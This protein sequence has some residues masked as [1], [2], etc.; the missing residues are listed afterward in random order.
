MAAS[1][2]AIATAVYLR[3]DEDRYDTPRAK[4][5]CA[6][7]PVRRRCLQD[8]I[9]D[10]NAQGIRGGYRFHYGRPVSRDDI[11]QMRSE[12]LRVPVDIAPYIRRPRKEGGEWPSG[13][14]DA[15]GAEWRR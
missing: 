12:G 6:T 11:T 15:G 2:T 10:P 9:D 8:A 3:Y 5:I 13:S 4:D 14:S 7:C 1:L